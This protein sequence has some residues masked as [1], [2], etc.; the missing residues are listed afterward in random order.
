MS[1][2]LAVGGVSNT[3]RNLLSDR[4]ELPPD[5]SDSDLQVTIGTPSEDDDTS[6]TRINLFLYK[7]TRSASLSNQ[8]IPG[9][10]HPA[11]F[12]R[13]PLSL[14]LHYLLTA[15]GTSSDKH[16]D[17]VDET[18]AQYLLGSA[19]RV[20]H[21]YPVIT[22]ELEDSTSQPILDQSLH[23]QFEQMKITL[24]PVSLEDVTTIWTA[25]TLPYRL[26]IG[27]QVSIVQIES[28]GTRRYPKPVGA[29]PEAGPRI[30]TVT[31]NTPRI[32]TLEVK[33]Q[34]T[35]SDEP[36]DRQPY[37]RIGDT[38]ILQG[39]G[40]VRGEMIANVVGETMA[41][42]VNTD[43]EVQVTLADVEALQPGARSVRLVRQ[44]TLG[45]PPE[46]RP[47]FKSN[48]AVFMLVPRVTGVNVTGGTVRVTGSRLYLE[49]KP[50]QT[51]IGDQITEAEAYTMATPAEI[52][53]PLPTLT[54]GT[55]TVRVRV[56]GAE[57]IDAETVTV[58]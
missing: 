38:L 25:L 9:H 10:G 14:E 19:M 58:T 17:F 43:Q 29:P 31:L 55:Y 5:V 50:C 45:D 24:E 56:N 12:G 41:A 54:A 21:D 46:A 51:I 27:Y 2:Y 28:Q 13:P 23:G 37:A 6:T 30:T 32:D 18:L 42:S 7:V 1:N 33:K 20:L 57:S 52:R 35:P 16:D 11:A 49:N 4:M 15:Y 39:G 48:L 47:G 26:S 34:G 40:F 8:E 3:I 22:E 36:P 53:F 44:V